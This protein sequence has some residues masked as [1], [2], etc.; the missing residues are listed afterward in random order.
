MDVFDANWKKNFKLHAMIFCTIN[1]FPAYGN[2]S[3]YSVK[4]HK[5][6]SLC[7]KSTCYHQLQHGK[8]TIYFGH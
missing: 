5:V 2:L 3:E 6:C 7:E 4:D 8:K 1:D